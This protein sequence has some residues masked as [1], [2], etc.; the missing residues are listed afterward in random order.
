MSDVVEMRAYA[1]GDEALR[2][3]VAVDDEGV[4]EA[5]ALADLWCLSELK[6]DYAR[7]I[8]STWRPCNAIDRYVSCMARPALKIAFKVCHN[9]ARTLIVPGCMDECR[10]L[11]ARERGYE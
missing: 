11:W 4:M 1:H 5:Y 9:R 3:K 2:S 10:C 8:G 6:E 7:Y